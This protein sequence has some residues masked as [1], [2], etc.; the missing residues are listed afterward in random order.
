MFDVGAQDASLVL[1]SIFKLIQTVIL[2]VDQSGDQQRNFKFESFLFYQISTMQNVVYTTQEKLFNVLV[3]K[4]IKD[5][6]ALF[7]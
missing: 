4:R 2:V 3:I 7:K 6:A 1:E 5:L